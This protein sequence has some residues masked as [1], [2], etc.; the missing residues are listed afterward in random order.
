M[1]KSCMGIRLALS[2]GLSSAASTRRPP[3]SRMR[4]LLVGLL[5]LAAGL[6]LA[7]WGGADAEKQAR[8]RKYPTAIAMVL[9]S[10]VVTHQHR[11]SVDYSPCITY[12]HSESGRPLT[13]TRDFILP[14]RGSQAWAQELCRQY[15][16]GRQV[17]ICRS[18]L[19][20]NDT[21][22]FRDLSSSP[23]LIGVLGM[24]LCTIGS[25]L[26]AMSAT[27]D[28]VHAFTGAVLILSPLHLV[29]GILM[30]THRAIV[31]APLLDGSGLLLLLY[32]LI[33]CAGCGTLAWMLAQRLGSAG[34]GESN[35]DP[36]SAPVQSPQAG[37]PR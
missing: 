11:H 19:D 10:S 22:L 34:S 8:C 16:R 9:G 5:S 25:G 36:A 31:G 13:S 26:L 37:V 32:P 30:V 28:R 35:G 17:V 7:I 27:A 20:A 1:R 6:G 29:L 3:P 18:P 33:A 2:W 4:L 24:A 12:M 23:Y 21:F 15:P 14:C